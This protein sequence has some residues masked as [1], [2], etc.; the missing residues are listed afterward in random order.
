MG[1]DIIYDIAC[2]DLRQLFS[3]YFSKLTRYRGLRFRAIKDGIGKPY[4][5]AIETRLSIFYSSIK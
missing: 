3:K 2:Q 5:I 4:Q 1:N